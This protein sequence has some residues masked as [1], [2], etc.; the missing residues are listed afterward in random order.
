MG[1]TALSKNRA[2]E[3]RVVII[4]MATVSPL[5]LNVQDT[6]QAMVEGRS[7]VGYIT[8]FDASQ[9]PVRIAAE[10]KGFDPSTYV[11]PKEARRMARSSQMAI[12]TA[13]QALEDAGLS[14]PFEGEMAERVGAL[15][16]VSIGGFDEV[17]KAL[18][19]VWHDG[20]HKVSPFSLA[21]ALPN[22]PAFHICLRFN[23]QG[24][25]GTISTACS[26]GTQAIGEATEIIRRGTADIMIAGGVEAM[27]LVSTFA[28]FDAMR[29]LSHRNDDPA[30]ACRPF[31]AERDGLVIGEGCCIFVLERLTHALDRGSKIYAEI[32]GQASSSD[33]YHVAAPDPEGN[34]AIRAMRWAL[35]DAGLTTDDIDYI[36]AH[37]TATPRGDASETTAIK[38]LFGERAYKI[39][40]SAT[41]SMIG[42]VFGA[43]GPI[44]SLACVQ[45]INT[46]II[47]PTINYRTP[48]PECD[49]DVVPN[50]ARQIDVQVVLKNSFGFGGQ[51][52][53]LVIGKYEG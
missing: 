2:E 42:H 5:G 20:F 31:D 26:A 32:L 39:P 43:G 14:F 41:K 36:N 38:R 3:Q 48:D 33:T 51:N 47:H 7:G 46:G 16:G 53:C 37:A 40:V 45:T 23:A 52:T 29:A 11:S 13:I 25:T 30:G 17:E 34:G 4:G 49:L 6:W 35:Q 27:I 18:Y 22:V 19:T 1:G 28:G 8:L 24:Y 21:A 10:V 50:K 44:E 15:L 9:Y 12:V